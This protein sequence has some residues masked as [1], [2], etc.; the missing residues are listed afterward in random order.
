MILW[1]K[2]EFEDLMFID[3]QLYK[4]FK[5]LK[6]NIKNNDISNNEN[7]NN[8]I[9]DLGLDYSLQMK[10]CNNHLH[11]FEL[12]KSGRNIIVENLD[13]FKQKEINFLI[14]IYE[15]FISKIR[16]TFYKYMPIDKIKCLN[17]N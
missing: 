5:N 10:D 17:M 16:E 3:S 9:K 12:I 7:G 13:D 14:G 8:Y 11:T 2:I 6:D 15:P 4:T 1:E